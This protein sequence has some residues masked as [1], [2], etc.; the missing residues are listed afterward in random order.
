[1]AE[2]KIQIDKRNQAMVSLPSF[3]RDKFNL[4]Q[5]EI[6]D[7]DLNGTNIVIKTRK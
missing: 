5:G 7:V 1:M 2:R 4:K 3:I 6:V